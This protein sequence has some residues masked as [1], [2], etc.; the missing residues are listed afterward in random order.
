M[1]DTIERMVLESSDEIKMVLFRSGET[2]KRLE[3]EHRLATLKQCQ[4]MQMICR[5][6]C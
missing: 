2:K 6:V 3:K 5:N 4:E 1:W